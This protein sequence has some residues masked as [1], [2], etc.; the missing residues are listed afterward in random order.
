ML[1]NCY[2]KCTI[3]DGFS[4]LPILWPHVSRKNSSYQTDYTAF[5]WKKRIGF[6]LNASLVRN[7]AYDHFIHLTN[8]T[9]QSPFFNSH[10]ENFHVVIKTESFDCNIQKSVIPAFIT[11]AE[12]GKGT[13]NDDIKWLALFNGPTPQVDVSARFFTLK[14]LAWEIKKMQ[15]PNNWVMS[16]QMCAHNHYNRGID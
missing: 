8:Q 13:K 16:L 6:V 2:L 1:Q 15:R 11:K 10:I 14:L 12:G 3:K 9:W 4:Y 5:Q 7:L